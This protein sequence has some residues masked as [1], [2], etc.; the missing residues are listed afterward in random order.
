MPS[1]CREARLSM[2][3]VGA[4]AQL[5]WRSTNGSRAQGSVCHSRVHAEERMCSNEV[6]GSCAQQCRTMQTKA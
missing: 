2:R 1:V 3:R 4:G 5:R 6:A